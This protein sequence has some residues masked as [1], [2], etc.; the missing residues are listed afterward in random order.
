MALRKARYRGCLSPCPDHG[1]VKKD[2]YGKTAF[3]AMQAAARATSSTRSCHSDG[4]ATAT[5]TFQIY[6]THCLRRLV[7]VICANSMDDIL[8]YSA[9]PS[10]YY[11][12]VREVLYRLPG[13]HLCANTSKCK[14]NIEELSFLAR[15]L[16]TDGVAIEPDR[17]SAFCNWPHPTSI[18]AVPILLG[19]ANF[20]GRFNS[21][22]CSNHRV[23]DELA[24]RE[25]GR[26]AT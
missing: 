24:G 10:E 8:V 17:I 4:L 11:R 1:R 6:S 26:N 25:Q 19:F 16:W 7:D 15:I 12:H 20:Y 3:H 13:H 18:K 23:S 21:Q 2:D 9:D 22:I 14:F 5:A